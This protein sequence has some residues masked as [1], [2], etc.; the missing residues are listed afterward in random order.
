MSGDGNTLV[1]TEGFSGG[2]TAGTKIYVSTDGGI[3]WILQQFN[4]NSASVN[5]STDSSLLLVFSGND[6]YSRSPC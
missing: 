6:I 4:L 3:T 2:G 5:V 1:V